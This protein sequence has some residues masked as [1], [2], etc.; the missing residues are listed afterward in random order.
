MKKKWVAFV[1]HVVKW[2]WM[3]NSSRKTVASDPVTVLANSVYHHD[4][5]I[6]LGIYDS[7]TAWRPNWN[8]AAL[9]HAHSTSVVG[10][11]E[12][13]S[14]RVLAVHLA[15]RWRK[16]QTSRGKCTDQSIGHQW[17]HTTCLRQRD[18]SS[19]FRQ[20]HEAYH[21]PIKERFL[22]NVDSIAG[23][24]GLA[25]EQNVT[26]HLGVRINPTAHFQTA[27]HV[28]RWTREKN[29]SSEFSALQEASTTLQ[30]FVR[31]Q[32]L[33]SHESENAP[34]RWRTLRTAC[35]SVQR[36]ISNCTFNSI[37]Q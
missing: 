4:Q 26:N 9:R 37:V 27:A 30:R 8:E 11:V 22:Y 35:L 6:D 15:K 34:S 16:C 5:S 29:Y 1:T 24:M 12:E 17:H 21:D 18:V 2:E 13:H 23:K 31:S 33:W 36:P 20:F 3:Q 28:R 32:V 25:V 14:L 10:F 7:D 19:Y